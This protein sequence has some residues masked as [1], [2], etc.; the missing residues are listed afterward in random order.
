MLLFGPQGKV[1]DMLSRETLTTTQNN[2]L[3][4]IAACM[5]AA[6]ELLW[7]K[8]NLEHEL[9]EGRNLGLVDYIDL[10]SDL[11][12]NAVELADLTDRKRRLEEDYDYISN[13]LDSGE[14]S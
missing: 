6:R 9:A 14:Y 12:E 5:D 4:A 13:L 3:V 10:A 11:D 1:N 7:E 2:L 8:D